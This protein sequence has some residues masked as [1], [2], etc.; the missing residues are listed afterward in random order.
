MVIECSANLAELILDDTEPGGCARA[1]S[2]SVSV[3]QDFVRKVDGLDQYSTDKPKYAEVTMVDRT[4]VPKSTGHQSRG[5]KGRSSF[6]PDYFFRRDTVP[7]SAIYRES[8]TSQFHRR[9]Q[10]PR[11]NEKALE[12]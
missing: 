9:S 5:R 8:Y 3:T 2:P 6:G 7:F 12:S 10:R 11:R 4:R 1:Q